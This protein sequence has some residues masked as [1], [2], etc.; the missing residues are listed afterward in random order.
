MSDSPRLVKLYLRLPLDLSGKAYRD[1]L[2]RLLQIWHRSLSV[3]AFEVKEGPATELSM[4]TDIDSGLYQDAFVEYHRKHGWNMDEMTL[5]GLSVETEYLSSYEI[6][7]KAD[8]EPDESEVRIY[9]KRPGRDAEPRSLDCWLIKYDGGPTGADGGPS[10][11]DEIEPRTPTGA[12]G[13]RK[14]L[15]F[16]APYNLGLRRKL[17]RLSFKWERFF[18]DRELPFA[19]WDNFE[20]F[21][22]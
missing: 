19:R 10:A 9:W 1:E 6:T 17:N 13:Y 22:R 7:Y 14:G 20:E 12:T 4:Y 15:L 11:V 5:I 21:D 18:R 3:E 8:S 16:C 2:C